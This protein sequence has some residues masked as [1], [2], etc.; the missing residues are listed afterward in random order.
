VLCS[1]LMKPCKE[2]QGQQWACSQQPKT[3]SAPLCHQ[4]VT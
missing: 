1:S 4:G 2:G 3:L